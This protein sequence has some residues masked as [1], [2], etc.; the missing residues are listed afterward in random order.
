MIINIPLQIDEKIIEKN[1][2]V[3]Y[4]SKIKD[5]IL[6]EVEDAL[7]QRAKDMYRYWSGR[8]ATTTDGIRIYIHE[9]VDKQIQEWKDEIMY[10]A[11]LK[12]AERL[13]KT[14][15]GKE[16]LEKYDGEVQNN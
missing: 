10:E 15:K 12:L 3:D 9:Y 5:Y 7:I 8:D 14:K 2:S 6:K 4:E 13:S 1:L 16:I 11:A